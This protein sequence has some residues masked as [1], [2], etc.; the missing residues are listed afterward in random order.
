MAVPRGC[1]LSSPR[2]APAP[3]EHEPVSYR[4][5]VS[6][7]GSC[8]PAGA[9][10]SRLRQSAS[11]IQWSRSWP[12]PMYHRASLAERVAYPVKAVMTPTPACIP[13]THALPATPAVAAYTQAKRR[14][15]RPRRHHSPTSQC[16]RIGSLQR[17]WLQVHWRAMGMR[18]HL[19]RQQPQ[20]EQ[21]VRHAPGRLL[22]ASSH[23]RVSDDFV[24]LGARYGVSADGQPG[25]VR[26]AAG[27]RGRGVCNRCGSA[28]VP[29]L[30]SHLR[31]RSYLH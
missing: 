7:S 30:S 15:G 18:R 26:G 31:F 29:P 17:K 5:L 21:G 16:C 14:H 4:I 28:C 24:L 23:D 3:W 9:G 13:R 12:H 2:A 27:L 8:A 11:C 10:Q 20:R 1:A 19:R 25:G 22:G 6:G